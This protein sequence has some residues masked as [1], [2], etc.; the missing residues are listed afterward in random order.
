MSSHFFPHGLPL[1]SRAATRKRSPSAT[2]LAEKIRSRFRWFEGRGR[3]SE[4]LWRDVELAASTN[5]NVLIIGET[6]T[7]KEVVAKWIHAE[8]RRLHGLGDDDAPFVPINCAA[9]P[10][11]LVESILFGHERGAFTSARQVQR[12]K[13]E[14]A[15]KGSLFLDEIQNLNLEAQSKL[16][17][18]VQSREFERL[19]AQ[20]T[21][22]V[23]CQ[24]ITASN[25]PL[26]LL[27][28]KNQFRKDLYYRL[29]I[30]PIYLPALRARADDVPGL[31]QHYLTQICAQHGL[32]PKDIDDA[33]FALLREHSW[34]GNLRELEHGLLYASLRAKDNVIRASDLPATLTGEISEYL[35]TGTWVWN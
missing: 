24:I 11:N 12:G 13:F 10:E 31:V 16:L 9:L 8:R 19:G 1:S 7:G 30:C 22:N 5:I 32:P 4:T 35:K 20:S 18:V 28:E 6:G 26:E 14:I 27:I 17:R 21:D 3:L 34:P 23:Q 33:A 25:V 15:K 2:S 29:N